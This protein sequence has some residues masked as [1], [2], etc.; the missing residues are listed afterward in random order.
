MANLALHARQMVPRRTADRQR[1]ILNFDKAD[2]FAV[3]YYAAGDKRRRRCP[4]LRRAL[5]LRRSRA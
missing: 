5:R 4:S 2:N 1:P 3:A